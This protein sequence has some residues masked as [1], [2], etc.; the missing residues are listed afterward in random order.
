MPMNSVNT[1]VGAMV[2]LSSCVN[3]SSTPMLAG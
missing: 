1:N 2:A 3:R